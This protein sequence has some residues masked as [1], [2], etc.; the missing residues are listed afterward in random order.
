MEQF[1]S[2]RHA[3][4]H[5]EQ[6]SRN[7]GVTKRTI[8]GEY[9]EAID[10]AY[11]ARPKNRSVANFL[12]D[13]QLRQSFSVVFTRLLSGSEALVLCRVWVVRMQWVYDHRDDFDASDAPYAFVRDGFQV[14][15]ELQEVC[16][17]GGRTFQNRLRVMLMEM[18]IQRRD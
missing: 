11:V 17:L 8:L 12:R 14:P 3:H 2:N 9:G 10:I 13:T 6:D 15:P 4:V 16:R 18:P 5:L 7:F 1:S